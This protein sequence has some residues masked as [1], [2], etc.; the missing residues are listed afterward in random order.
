MPNYLR[1]VAN[2]LN[3]SGLQGRGD[4]LAVVHT[5]FYEWKI[6]TFLQSWEIDRTFHQS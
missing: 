5:R 3:C 2:E 1:Q 4:V 6:M